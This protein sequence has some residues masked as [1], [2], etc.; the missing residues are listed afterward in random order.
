MNVDMYVRAINIYRK[1]QTIKRE[2][3]LDGQPNVPS[4]LWCEIKDECQWFNSP[5]NQDF[6]IYVDGKWH[7]KL[8]DYGSKKHCAC[9][10][11]PST[12]VT[13]L[14]YMIDIFERDHNNEH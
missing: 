12:F 5:T 1:A 8:G 4:H 2:F 13:N 3:C 14:K 11:I 7:V 6:F 10:G 9:H